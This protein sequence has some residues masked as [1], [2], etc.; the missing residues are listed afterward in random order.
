MRSR[1]LRLALLAS[2]AL[3]LA[4]PPALAATEI[5]VAAAVNP[6]AHGTPPAQDSRVLRIGTDMTA[7]EKVA[8]GPRGQ[9]QLLFLDGSAL[10]VGP[11]SD[12]V[13]DAF[14]YDPETKDGELAFSATK[15]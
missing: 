8:T 4:A 15:G 13:L 1:R 10:T 5:G 2:T 14:V 12:I 7:N 3:G 9:A 11:N 6:M